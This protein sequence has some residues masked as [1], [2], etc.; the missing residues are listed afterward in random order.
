MNSYIICQK[1]C[2]L[3]TYMDYLCIYLYIILYALQFYNINCMLGIN[4]FYNF[5]FTNPLINVILEMSYLRDNFL[6]IIFR[7]K[8]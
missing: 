2:I 4:I 5:P 1:Y 3:N 8:H 7:N 6:I